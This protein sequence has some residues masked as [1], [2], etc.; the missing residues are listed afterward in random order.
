[1]RVILGSPTEVPRCAH[2]VSP[3]DVLPVPSSPQASAVGSGPSPAKEELSLEDGHDQT[4]VFF[5]LKE[6]RAWILTDYLRPNGRSRSL[7][8]S[9]RPFSRLDFIQFFT[10]SV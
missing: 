6:R 2:W 1:M 4:P 7:S 10:V 5:S 9:L 3:D 8:A